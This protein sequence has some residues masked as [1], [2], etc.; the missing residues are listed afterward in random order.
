MT[1]VGER[2]CRLWNLLS[3]GICGSL[4]HEADL[5]HESKSHDENNVQKTLSG[6]CHFLKLCICVH[7]EE[8]G[9]NVL[10]Q[11]GCG[12]RKCRVWQEKGRL[13]LLCVVKFQESEDCS[14]AT[15]EQSSGS[16]FWLYIKITWE[17][18]A[19]TPPPHPRL[20]KSEP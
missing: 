14:L 12:L 18:S 6:F 1:P 19:A 15:G 11:S 9:K 8:E 7:T 10:L 17:S 2:M 13:H 20:S 16:C 4:N 5:M 3:I